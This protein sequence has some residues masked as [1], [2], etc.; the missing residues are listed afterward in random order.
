VL[1]WD[2]AGVARDH[3][4]REWLVVT[5]WGVGVPHLCKGTAFEASGQVSARWSWVA[6]E[7]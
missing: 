6:S 7:R 4:C 1:K 3:H 2:H 5:A